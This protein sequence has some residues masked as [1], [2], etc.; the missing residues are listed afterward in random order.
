VKPLRLGVLIGGGGRTLLNLADRIDAGSLHATIACV[1]A[2]RETIPGVERARRRGLA[3]TVAPASAEPAAANHDAITSCL[4][5][6]GVDLV[7]LAGYL[8]WL[9]IDEPFLGRV[10]NIH[11]A[12]LPAFGGTGMYGERV[13]RAVLAHGCKV[14]GCTVHFV[15]EHYDHG[16]II[17]QKVCPVAD[18]DTAETLAA[19]V[20][21]LEREAYPE[22][23]NLQAAGRLRVE[24]RRVRVLAESDNR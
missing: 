16:P 22:A 10:M 5:D 8:R 7:C 6:S 9:R 1:I 11:P 2:P 21:E 23:I 18:D 20:F 19:R 13:H 12:L 17:L 3:V 14:S 15:D 4:Q 24:G